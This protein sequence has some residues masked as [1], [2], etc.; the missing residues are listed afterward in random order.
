MYQTRIFSSFFSSLILENINRSQR[1]KKLVIK[2]KINLI[3]YHSLAL[4]FFCLES[5]RKER[6]GKKKGRDLSLMCSDKHA[7]TKSLFI[8]KQ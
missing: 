8:H 7:P 4:F 3:A 5:K 1:L 6:K 2:N